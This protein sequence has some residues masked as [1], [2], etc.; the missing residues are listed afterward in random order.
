M[1]NESV[2]ATIKCPPIKRSGEEYVGK[3]IRQIRSML[4]DALEIADGAPVSLSTDGGETFTN[5][6]DENHVIQDKEIV[7]F[8]RGS[9]SKG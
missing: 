3:T 8:G 2:C 1:A 7:E 4:K 9:S 5:V 6:G